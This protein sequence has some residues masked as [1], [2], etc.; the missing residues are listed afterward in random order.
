MESAI[1]QTKEACRALR[2]QLQDTALD[3]ASEVFKS[4]VDHCL[5][6]A[7][8]TAGLN[9]EKERVNE[10]SVKFEEH[11][12]QLQEVQLSHAFNRIN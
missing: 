3:Q 2:K 10:T 8:K 4:N 9:A 12:E 11:S 6:G 1:L 7:M 5:L